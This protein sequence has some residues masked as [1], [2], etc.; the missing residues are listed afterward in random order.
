MSIPMNLMLSGTSML[1]TMVDHISHENSTLV[2]LDCSQ[3]L[4]RDLTRD[5]VVRSIKSMRLNSASG[6][7]GILPIMIA[8]GG[9]RMILILSVVLYGFSNYV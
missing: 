8:K 6:P 3:P 1:K 7:D 5:E 4:N 2:S 9:Q